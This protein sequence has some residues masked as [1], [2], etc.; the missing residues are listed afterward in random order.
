MFHADG[1]RRDLDGLRLTI[2]LPYCGLSQRIAA[3][4]KDSVIGDPFYLLAPSSIASFTSQPFSQK[5][6]A[7]LAQNLHRLLRWWFSMRQ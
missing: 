6:E 5:E 2:P 1:S 4:K 7:T 3:A